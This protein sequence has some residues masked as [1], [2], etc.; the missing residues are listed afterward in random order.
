MVATASTE[1]SY[2]LGLAFVAWKYA[3]HATQAIAFEW[4]PG[5]RQRNTDV[6]GQSA[7][8]S[9][10]WFHASFPSDT[11]TAPRHSRW[12][13]SVSE[14][15]VP[16]RR[17]ASVQQPHARNSV[18]NLQQ[19]YSPGVEKINVFFK[20][21]IWFFG[22]FWVIVVFCFFFGFFRFKSRKPKI[23]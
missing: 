9:R 19:H 1:H 21:E 17:D 22:F 13:S 7:R 16:D 20:L 23:A 10:N 15:Q 2:W 12:H 18:V 4:K 14:L 3:T 6:W 5:L 8:R 11:C